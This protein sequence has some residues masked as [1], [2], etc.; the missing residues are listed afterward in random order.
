M[1][2]ALNYTSVPWASFLKMKEKDWFKYRGYPHLSNIVPLSKRKVM[3]S[4]VQKPNLISSHSFLPFI[5]KSIIQRRYKRINGYENS[6]RAHKLLKDGIVRSSKKTRTIMYSCH[7]D[8]HV[9]AYYAMKIIQ[10]K[11]ESLLNQNNNINDAVIA[12]RKLPV[13]DGL[14]NKNNIYF[15]KEVFD[16]IKERK[17]CVALLFDIENFFPSLNHKQLKLA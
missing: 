9:Y 2:V 8:A 3:E 10:P 4:Y 14:R 1:Y 6:K 17:N 5:S 13:G 12:Y 7:Q 15:A 16:E 11:Y